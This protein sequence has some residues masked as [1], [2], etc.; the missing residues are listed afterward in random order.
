MHGCEIW[1]FGEKCLNSWKGGIMIWIYTINISTR[2][3]FTVDRCILLIGKLYFKENLYTG[4]FLL[5]SSPES[6]AHG[7]LL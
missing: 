4:I 2:G 6:L 7:E 1:G 5:F 3:V